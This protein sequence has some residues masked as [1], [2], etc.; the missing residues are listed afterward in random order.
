M[1]RRAVVTPSDFPTYAAPRGEL[2]R[3]VQVLVNRR[4]S[5]ARQITIGTFTIPPG[6]KSRLDAHA[7][8]E[9]A[10]YITQG[11]GHVVIDGVKYNVNTGA[12]VHI[13][14]GRKHQS[15]NTGNED[16]KFIWFFPKEMRR[17]RHE[18]ERWP[19]VRA[20]A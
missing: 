5:G 10:Y 19:S 7:G 9:E 15:F 3:R 12:V 20:S 13:G 18:V 4:I 8:V 2:P 1:Q 16:L 11:R 14:A 6:G 17:L